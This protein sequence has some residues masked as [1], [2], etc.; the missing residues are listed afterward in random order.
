MLLLK[1]LLSLPKLWQLL[2]FD[3]DKIISIAT[4]DIVKHD[5]TA[6]E[7]HSTMAKNARTP[8]CSG[9]KQKKECDA[10]KKGQ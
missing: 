7:G 2:P 3:G 9:A 10:G 6:H 8:K 4:R 1:G 5:L